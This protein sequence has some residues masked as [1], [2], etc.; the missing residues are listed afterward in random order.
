VIDAVLTG[1]PWPVSLNDL[2]TWAPEGAV[3]SAER[4]ALARTLMGYARARPDT[5][6][7]R[8][9]PVIIYD[10]TAGRRWFMAAVRALDARGSGSAGSL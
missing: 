6:G 3:G 4:L 10:P 7:G 9:A 1:E 5:V 8:K 2:L